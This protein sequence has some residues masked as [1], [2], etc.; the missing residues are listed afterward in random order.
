MQRRAVAEAARENRGVLM[1]IDS[2]L[3]LLFP[4]IGIICIVAMKPKVK[5][6]RNSTSIGLILGAVI[7]GAY[8]IWKFTQGGF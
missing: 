7:V 8:I 4:L 3:W 2:A 5:Q 1:R 6:S